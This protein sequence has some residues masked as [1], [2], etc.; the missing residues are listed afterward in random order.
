ME[1]DQ[2]NA[3]VSLAADRMMR[4]GYAAV[5]VADLCRDAAVSR[6]DFYRQY[7]SKAGLGVA[8]VERFSNAREELLSRAFRDG[9]PIR[10]QIQ[11]MFSL[12]Q[13][14]QASAR[15]Q[16]GRTPGSPFALMVG[17]GDDDPA[18]RAAVGA[19]FDACH[20]RLRLALNVAVERKEIRLPDPD[21]AARALLVFV[22]G[23]LQH[24]RAMDDPGVLLVLAPASMSLLID[25]RATGA[26]P[27]ILASGTRTDSE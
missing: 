14:E 10:G 11:R 2:K 9:L 3:L 25:R 27:I 18:I 4:C 20:W 23:A 13:A 24:A 17:D 21:F 19:A 26:W 6:V 22:E 8:V 16:L 7:G 1:L 12:F 5:T 15:K